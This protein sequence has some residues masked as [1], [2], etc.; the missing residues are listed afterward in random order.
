MRS[1]NS[2]ASFICLVLEK[3]WQE[4]LFDRA[5]AAGIPLELDERMRKKWQEDA[6]SQTI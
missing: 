4:L 3:S 1:L 5:V 2:Y 6:Q